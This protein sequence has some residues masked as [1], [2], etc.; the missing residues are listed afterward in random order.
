MDEA[1]ALANF[2]ELTARSI[3]LNYSKHLPLPPQ[4]VVLCGGGASNGFLASRIRM[5][6]QR[7]NADVSVSTSDEMGWPNQAVEPAA[8][9]LLAYYRW[10]NL[11]A[12]FPATTGA[13]RPVLLGQISEP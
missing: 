2:T 6:L 10:N 12:N 5:A 8:F 13:S 4:S 7:D 11:A 1:E 3:A 9:A